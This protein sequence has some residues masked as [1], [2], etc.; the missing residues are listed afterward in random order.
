[1]HSVPAEENGTRALR[2]RRRS[3]DVVGR[4]HASKMDALLVSW[5]ARFFPKMTRTRS[6]TLRYQVR[7]PRPS[8]SCQQQRPNLHPCPCPR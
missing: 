5:L 4:I 8:F 1:M 2:H 6:L 3:L 7:P